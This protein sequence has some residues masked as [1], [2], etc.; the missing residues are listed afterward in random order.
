LLTLLAKMP[1]LMVSSKHAQ[2]L[3]TLTS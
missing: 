1:K 3:K 2:E